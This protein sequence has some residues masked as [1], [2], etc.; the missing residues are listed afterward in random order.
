MTRRCCKCGALWEWEHEGGALFCEPHSRTEMVEALR[1][2]VAERD[3]MIA[4]L[5]AMVYRAHEVA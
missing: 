3:G 5:Q 2:Q 1:R 4:E